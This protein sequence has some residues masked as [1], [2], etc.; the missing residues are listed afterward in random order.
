MMEQVQLAEES[1]RD[2]LKELAKKV[3]AEIEMELA[4]LASMKQV[5]R[6]GK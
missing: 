1:G 6:D 5:F 3:D 2:L 4:R